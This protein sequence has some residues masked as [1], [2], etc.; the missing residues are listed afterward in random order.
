MLLIFSL[1]SRPALQASAVNW[2]DFGIKKT[3]HFTEYFILAWLMF[4]SLRQSIKFGL[5]ALLTLTLTLTVLYAASDEYHQTFIVG[6]EGRPRDVLI[7]SVGA[8]TA[9]FFLRRN[10]NTTG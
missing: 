6:R 8:L 3:A 5:T 9:C 10:H 1:S 4:R 2:L 7:D